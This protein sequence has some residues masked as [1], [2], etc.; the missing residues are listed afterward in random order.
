MGPRRK[1]NFPWG[2]CPGFVPSSVWMSS[3]YWK[4]PLLDMKSY[5]FPCLNCPY[6]FKFPSKSVV[7]SLHHTGR[8]LSWRYPSFLHDL[9]CFL[10]AHLMDSLVDVEEPE[11]GRGEERTISFLLPKIAFNNRSSLS[12]RSEVFQTLYLPLQ[13]NDLFLPPTETD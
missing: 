9:I 13:W 1:S 4:S 8:S 6:S 11:N 7:L 12:S 5:S 3:K 2:F 10:R